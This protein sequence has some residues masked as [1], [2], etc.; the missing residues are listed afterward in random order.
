ML[1]NFYS[2]FALSNSL[3]GKIK[4]QNTKYGTYIWQHSLQKF[5]TPNEGYEG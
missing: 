5:R 2:Y 4:N 3:L 1:S